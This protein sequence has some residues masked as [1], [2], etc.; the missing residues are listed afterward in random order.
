MGRILKLFIT[1][2]SLFCFLST[3]SIPISAAQSSSSD[4]RKIE[5]A[6]TEDLEINEDGFKVSEQIELSEEENADEMHS[7]SPMVKEESS[8]TEETDTGSLPNAEMKL[9]EEQVQ[10]KAAEVKEE[11]T[12]NSEHPKE[13]VQPEEGQEDVHLKTETGTGETTKKAKEDTENEAV[14]VQQ[15]EQF[16]QPFQAPSIADVSLLTGTE[17]NAEH[18]SVENGQEQ[19]KLIFTGSSVLNLGI[20][21]NSYITFQLP[22]EIIDAL[23]NDPS[24]SLTATYE[25]PIISIGNGGLVDGLLDLIGDILD[26]PITTLSGEFEGEDITIDADKNLIELSF[27]NFLSLALLDQSHKFVLTITLDELPLTESPTY[28]FSA[29]ATSKPILDVSIMPDKGWDWDHLPAAKLAFNRVPP[30]LSFETTSIKS[31]L[32][33]I[34]REDANWSLEVIDTRGQGSEF[35]ILAEAEQPLTTADGSHTLPDALVYVDEN[36]VS[37]SLLEGPVE[38]YAGQTGHDSFT[39]VQWEP[40][41]GPMVE[42]NPMNAYARSYETTITWTLVDA[43]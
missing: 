13:A 9:R 5:E 1:G 7:K 38:V 26:L 37:H 3:V 41:Q 22:P 32:I 6:A 36:F 8:I 25:V 11:T 19:I 16:L 39:S 30:T 29:F 33:R 24:A 23:L 42:V 15:Q 12:Y 14:S 31:G 2:I 17:L 28:E 20:L 18:M 34:P 35:R 21:E 10:D 4:E 43:P 40:D 27:G